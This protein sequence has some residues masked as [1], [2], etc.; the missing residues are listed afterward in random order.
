MKTRPL[1]IAGSRLLRTHVVLVQVNISSPN[2]ITFYGFF[3]AFSGI[4]DMKKYFAH[5][6]GEMDMEKCLT[7]AERW[8]KKRAIRYLR[9]ELKERLDYLDGKP[10]N[11]CKAYQA[12]IESMKNQIGAKDVIEETHDVLRAE[13]ISFKAL[14]RIFNFFSELTPNERDVVIEASKNGEFDGEFGDNGRD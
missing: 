2:H 14:L 9:G 10:D 3:V 13:Q 7:Q 12:I 5:T 1:S 6:K 11:L 8:E 4:L